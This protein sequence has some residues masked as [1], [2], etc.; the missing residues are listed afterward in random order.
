MYA[1][2]PL[3]LVE[4]DGWVSHPSMDDYRWITPLRDTQS[5]LSLENQSIGSL[6]M[7]TYALSQRLV[8]RHYYGTQIAFHCQQRV[9]IVYKLSQ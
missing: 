8:L 6:T 1:A 4:I 2:R 7:N 9:F 5:G 3:V